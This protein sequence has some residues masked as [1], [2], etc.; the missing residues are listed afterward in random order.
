PDVLVS[1]TAPKEG[2]K[3]FKSQHFLGGRFVPKA[4][5]DIYWLN[6]HDYPS[7]AQIVELPPVDGAHRS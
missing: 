3:L 1:L 6:L 7:F 4:F 5:A 2:V